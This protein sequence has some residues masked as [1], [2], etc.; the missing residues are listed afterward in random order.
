MK[1]DG[2]L[3]P[4]PPPRGSDF[5]PMIGWRE[6][7]SLSDLGVAWIKAKVDTGARSS[8]IHAV[9]L[10]LDARNGAEIVRFR[11]FPNQRNELDSVLCEAPVKEFREIR[12]SNGHLSRRPVIVTSLT[13]NGQTYP[14]ELTL[15]DRSHMGFRMLLGREAFRRRFCIDPGRSYRGG[16]P[17]SKS[18]KRIIRRRKRP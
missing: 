7:V 18:G 13:I 15:A 5:R 2:E 16:K 10:E 12:S 11:I 14:V 9:D 17:S 6:W 8:S 4:V 1:Q 3:S